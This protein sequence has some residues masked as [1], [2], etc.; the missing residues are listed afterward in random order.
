MEKKVIYRDRQEL[1]S[2]DLNNTQD[3]ADEAR[4]HLVADA[5]TA[6]RQYVGL[7]VTAASATEIG[8]AAGR[9]YDGTTGKVY[10]LAAAQTQSV[11]SM[12]PLQDKKWLAVS[13]FGQEEDTDIEPRDFLIDL[14]TREVE[15]QA[16][17][18]KRSRTAV[19]HIAQG[20]ESATPERP[21]APTGYTLIAHVRLS[22]TGIQEVALAESRR[23]PNLQRVE[24]RLTTAEGWITAAEPRLASI[25]SDIAGV[26]SEV[27]K[28]ASLEHVA[29]LGIDMAKVKERLEIPDDYVFYGADHFLDDDESETTNPAYSASAFEGVRPAVAAEQTLSLIHI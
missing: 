26:S 9:L 27:T 28:R 21:E 8:I 29:Q 12:L 11:F 3:W 24:A 18:M 22:P 19:V 23:L 10:A 5:I 1:Q 4:Q 16:V 15:P 13:V 25:M 7:A 6:E 20:L 17:A 2:A 14:Q